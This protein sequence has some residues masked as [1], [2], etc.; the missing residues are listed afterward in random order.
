MINKY[1]LHRIVFKIK[2]RIKAKKHAAIAIGT[3]SL[4]DSKQNL[5]IP[6]LDYDNKTIEEVATD[7]QKL[8]KRF[9]LRTGYI[10]KSHNGFHA[11]FPF[12]VRSWKE[13]KNIIRNSRVDWRYKSFADEYGRTF[14]R[15]AGKYKKFDI[16][17][18]GI[19]K[20]PYSASHD[21]CIIGNGILESH[22]DLFKLNNEINFKG[23]LYE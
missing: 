23:M 11:I 8:T 7:L 18:V 1:I 19:T 16:K 6:Y 3:S 4:I 15:V 14:L 13:V 12:D 9:Q 21:E 22:E 10:F 2:N 17:F 5:H 20:S